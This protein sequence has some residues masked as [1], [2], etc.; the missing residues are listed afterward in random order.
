LPLTQNAD[1]TLT[2][3][4]RATNV[5]GDPPF[6]A[7]HVE[8]G[9]A[10]AATELNVLTAFSV[11]RNLEFTGSC[12][13]PAGSSPPCTTEI[14]IS[15]TRLDSGER[16]GSVDIDWSLALKAAVPND[17]SFSRP[18]ELPWTVEFASP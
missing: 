15:F 17:E 1:A 14:L 9:G 12:D 18:T 7:V 11:V 2:G 3:S 13:A 4:L 8:R 16:G 5:A 6:V 10:P